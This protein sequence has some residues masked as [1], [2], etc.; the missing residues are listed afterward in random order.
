MRSEL[1]PKRRWAERTDSEMYSI[2]PDDFE[3][4]LKT[5]PSSEGL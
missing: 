1:Q 5:L 4:V 2:T 3:V